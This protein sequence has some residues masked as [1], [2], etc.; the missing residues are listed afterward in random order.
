MIEVATTAM[1]RPEILEKT[2][3]SFT[4]NITGVDWS[5]S[6]CYLNIDPLP[7]KEI[8]R[9]DTALVACNYFGKVV[10]NMPKKANYTLAYKWLWSQPK[11]KFFINIEDDWELLEKVS[12]ETLLRGFDKQKI[13]VP[14]RAYSYLYQ[15]CPT[16]PSVY[17]T[18]FFKNVSDFMK[19]NENPETQLHEYINTN[20]KKYTDKKHRLVNVYPFGKNRI[21]LKDIGRDWMDKTNYVR[22]QMLDK[23][24]KRYKKKC[25]FT[26]WIVRG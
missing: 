12:L 5:K 11:K 6:I 1:P 24:D 16:S 19:G 25:H 15:T 10:L 4:K 18:S 21:I 22:P 13:A 3:R 2:Y 20:Y 26:K 17:R 14:L 9:E 7:G 23:E 8:E